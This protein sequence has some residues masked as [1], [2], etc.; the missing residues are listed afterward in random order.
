MYTPYSRMEGLLPVPGGGGPVLYCD[1]GQ[2]RDDVQVMRPAL[3][4]F[5]SQY[6]HPPAP[7]PQ[8]TAVGATNPVLRPVVCFAYIL[9]LK[10]LFS[11]KRIQYMYMLVKLII[12]L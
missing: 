12:V 2:G 5:P 6:C 7:L 8:V 4:P 3:R 1:T 10:K 9:H 11:C